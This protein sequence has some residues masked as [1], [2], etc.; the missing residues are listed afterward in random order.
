[1]AVREIT[2]DLISARSLADLKAII[3]YTYGGQK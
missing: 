2:V 3:L 1:M